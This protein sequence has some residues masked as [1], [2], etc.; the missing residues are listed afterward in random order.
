MPR[1]LG[2][3]L[4]PLCVS[5]LGLAA[6]GQRDH[7]DLVFAQRGPPEDSCYDAKQRPRYCIPDFLDLA[8][9]QEVLASSTCGT[10]PQK[11]CSFQDPANITSRRCQVCD[12]REPRTSYP[13][14]HLTDADTRTCWR[15]EGGVKFPR[16]VTL[17]L[18]LG[19]RFEL[20]YL[21]LRF[22][23][24]RPESMAVFK[25]MDYGRSWTPMQYFSA[26]CRRVYGHPTSGTITKAMEHEATCTDY[27]TGLKPLTGGLVAFMPL[28]GRPSARRFEYSHVLQDWVTA[29]DVQVV[30]SRLQA[31]GGLGMRRKNAFYGVSE[32]QVGGR[33]KCNGHASRC[34]GAPEGL[35]CECRHNTAGP[36]CDRCKAFHHDRPWQRAMP[37]NA[38][39]CV[40]CEC[41]LHSHRCRFSMELYVLSGR[42]SGGICSSCRHSTAG[43]HCHY[44]KPGHKR[45]PG[46]PI[47]SRKACRPCQ[48][49]P[50]GAVN[51]VC[52]Q[53]TGQC[54]CKSGVTGLT[55]NR[56]AQ[57]FQQS[58]SAHMP[59]VRIR[60]EVTT[61]A[62]PPLVWNTGTECQTYCKPSHGKAHMNLWKYCTKD[63][64]LRAQILAMEKSGEWW[65]F[66]ASISTVYRQRRV[67]IRRGDQPLWVPEQDLA[68]ACL[69]LQVGHSYLVIAN[70]EESPD[71][72]RL[73]LDRNSLALPWRDAWAHKLRRFQQLNRRGKCKGA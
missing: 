45:D 24:P 41:N 67:P 33:C 34:A 28:A 66:T 62:D 25:S 39:E 23:A 2:G 22:C 7:A 16:N 6:R 53:T 60:E 20:V 43:R 73:V 14:A 70:D 63:Y 69:R 72:S 65:E 49:H 9:D 38:H 46:K 58:R 10:V 21:S 27:Q 1:A 48:C 44:C 3:L 31:S 4:I 59:C 54:Q 57:G 52:N 30:F 50:I 13:P 11:L 37:S 8:L 51:A 55:C 68:C 17:T 40:A 26:H 36:E 56:C 29:T 12:Q 5:L 19:R 15:S 47:T 32:L 61:T 18:P 64:V 42:R 35:V 71:P